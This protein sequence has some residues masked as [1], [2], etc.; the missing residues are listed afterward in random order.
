MDDMVS[1]LKALEKRV[2]DLEEVSDRCDGCEKLI[3]GRVSSFWA[4]GRGNFC[5][6][7]FKSWWHQEQQELK[8]AKEQ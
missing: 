8:G 2:S 7:C 6:G 3:G 1:R 5:Q 4:P